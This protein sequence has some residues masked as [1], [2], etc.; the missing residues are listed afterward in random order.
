LDESVRAQIS[1]DAFVSRIERE[2]APPEWQPGDADLARE[3]YERI[4]DLHRQGMNGLWA[5]LLK[6]NFAPLT[7]GK[8]DYIVGNP[9]WVNWEH[10]PDGYRQSIAPLWVSKYQLFPHRGFDAILGKSKDSHYSDPRCGGSFSRNS[11]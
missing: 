10:L 11:L 9:P 1:P 4:L 8:F 5:R 7:E 2:L 6:N 3:V